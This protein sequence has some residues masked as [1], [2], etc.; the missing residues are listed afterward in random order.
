MSLFLA[1][2]HFCVWFFPCDNWWFILIATQALREESDGHDE[3]V[4]M[5]RKL[6]DEVLAR[7]REELNSLRKVITITHLPIYLLA[8]F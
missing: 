1:V 7:L 6:H 5:M 2:L 3:E 4:E 8:V